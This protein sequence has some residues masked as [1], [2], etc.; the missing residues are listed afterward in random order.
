M[1]GQQGESNIQSWHLNKCEIAYNLEKTAATVGDTEAPEWKL[2]VPKIMPLIEKGLPQEKPLSISIQGMFWN[3]EEC[4]VTVQPTIEQRNYLKATRHDNCSF[5]FAY[6]H[7]DIQ[8]EVEILH[9]N[10]SNLRVTNHID[11]ST[12]N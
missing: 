10:P 4:K 5:A 3:A 12:P 6:K 11:N 9:D 7:H 2:Y 8:L 1:A